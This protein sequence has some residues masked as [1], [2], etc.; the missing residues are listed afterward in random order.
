MLEAVFNCRAALVRA[1]RSVPCGSF[2]AAALAADASSC[3]FCS[4]LV[5][6]P[7]IPTPC[8]GENTA[9]PK[10]ESGLGV[11]GP[12]RSGKKLWTPAR[13]ARGPERQYGTR[14]R[15]LRGWG[16]APN[17]YQPFEVFPGSS[18]QGVVYMR[19]VSVNRSLAT[20]AMCIWCLTTFAASARPGPRPILKRPTSKPF[21]QG[22][23]GPGLLQLPRHEAG[24]RRLLAGS[25][26]FHRPSPYSTE[27]QA[28]PRFYINFHNRDQKAKHNV[29][30]RDDEG[31][32]VPDL[33][34]AR[35]GA[36]ISAREIVADN[37]KSGAIAPLVTVV[38]TDDSGQVVM[39]ISA[40]DVL[41]EPL[42]H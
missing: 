17:A 35:K 26:T 32:D 40:K 38:I 23:I 37:I 15:H 34:E 13:N 31:I 6:L 11:P 14:G 41:P 3:Q 33:E 1:S 42:K 24:Q 29:L 9:V 21:E 12:E 22:E 27:A 20:T 39:T 18:G 2:S 10:H 8:T 5:F 28:M 7:M 30:A 19:P 25:G 4:T 16:A 36:L